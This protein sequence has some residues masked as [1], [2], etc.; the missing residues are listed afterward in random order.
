MNIYQVYLVNPDEPNGYQLVALVK[1]GCE[2]E[3][4]ERAKSEHSGLQVIKAE[5]LGTDFE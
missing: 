4:I 5:K 3:A 1:A 2:S